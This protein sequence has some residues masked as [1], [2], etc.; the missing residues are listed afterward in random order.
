MDATLLVRL[1]H[2]IRLETEQ[3]EKRLLQEQIHQLEVSSNESNTKLSKQIDN[4]SE[5]FSN[6]R[7]ND[8]FHLILVERKAR[9]ETKHLLTV[10][11]RLRETHSRDHV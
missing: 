7:Q 4:V 11:T 8:E 2:S 1:A 3:E 6:D 10:T 5:C 9:R